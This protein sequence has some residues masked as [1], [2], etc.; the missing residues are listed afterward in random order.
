MSRVGAVA[1]WRPAAPKRRDL[2]LGIGM[3]AMIAAGGGVRIDALLAAPQATGPS[4]DFVATSRFVTGSDLTDD[5]AI[6]R[7]WSQ[8]VALDAHFP[9]A[10]AQLGEAIRQG[11]ARTMAEFLASPHGQDAALLKTARTIT[12]AWYLGY[13]GT[14]AAQS[15][16]DDTGFVTFVG[17]LMWRP[18]IDATVIPTYS[19]GATD[20]WIDPPAGTPVPTGAAGVRDWR[21]N[22]AATLSKD[23]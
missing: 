5:A 1:R 2:L 7:A 12:A 16:K 23:A 22:G 10:V 6:A 19:R 14:F 15:S 8:L 4:A 20:F 11:G 21:G 9:A 13:T 17:A 3:T 18:T